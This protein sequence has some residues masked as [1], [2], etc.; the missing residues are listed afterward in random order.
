M[1]SRPRVQHRVPAKNLQCRLGRLSVSAVAIRSRAKID[2]GITRRIK[3]TPGGQRRRRRSQLRSVAFSCVSSRINSG[4]AFRRTSHR[5]CR[6]LL[7]SPRHRRLRDRCHQRSDHLLQ[8]TSP[9]RRH[10]LHHRLLLFPV[11]LVRRPTAAPD[12]DAHPMLQVHHR[13]HHRHLHRSRSNVRCRPAQ[14]RR[15]RSFHRNHHRHRHDCH[16]AS[17]SH[18]HPRR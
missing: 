13:R 17:H 11:L 10:H 12:R 9:Q 3:G 8:S 7:R 16:R 18:R 4:I 6:S 1:P 15:E 14:V 2:A 5:R